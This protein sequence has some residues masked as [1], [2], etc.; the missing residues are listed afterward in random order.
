MIV[1][2]RDRWA[3][4]QTDRIEHV[5]GIIVGGGAENGSA[6]SV[7]ET[8]M[9]TGEPLGRGSYDLSYLPRVSGSHRLHFLLLEP[10]INFQMHAGLDLNGILST[11]IVSN[12][13]FDWG[14]YEMHQND[15]A[16]RSDLRNSRYFL[17]HFSGMV[18]F[19][20]AE[21]FTFLIDADPD[22]ILVLMIDGAVIHTTG[23]SSGGVTRSGSHEGSFYPSNRNLLHVF[24]LTY[25]HK[26]GARAFVRCSW[27]RNPTVPFV[28]I[29]HTAFFHGSLAG[30]K[31][32]ETDIVSGLGDGRS[33]SLIKSQ[34]SFHVASWSSIAL[35]E[36]RD[37]CANLRA[38]GGD[39]PAIFIHGPGDLRVTANMTDFGN[40]TYEATVFAKT[41]GTRAINAF[42]SAF[43]TNQAMENMIG[44]PW[45]LDFVSISFSSRAAFLGGNAMIAGV[46]AG[47]PARI[48]LKGDAL[49]N[50]DSKM[51]LVVT[52]DLLPRN[53]CAQLNKSITRGVRRQRHLIDFVLYTIGTYHVQLVFNDTMLGMS[54]KL[55]CRSGTMSPSWSGVRVM[56]SVKERLIDSPL[57]IQARDEFG[58]EIATGGE[59]IWTQLYGPVLATGVSYD[60]SDGTYAILYNFR[61]LSPGKYAMHV[62]VAQGC[63]RGQHGGGLTAHYFIDGNT[64]SVPAVVREESGPIVFDWG[65]KDLVDGAADHVS[66]RWTGLLEAPETAFFR[67]VVRLSDINDVA[68]VSIDD[69]IVTET[70]AGV[71]FGHV[72]LTRGALYGISVE[73]YE[74]TG[75]AAISVEWS[76][77]EMKAQPVGA[78]FLF[79]SWK[80]LRGSPYSFE[81]SDRGFFQAPT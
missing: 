40:G 74:S 13:V 57:L 48:I 43:A 68:R 63:S 25:V 3:N 72:Y 41:V 62:D 69:A 79:P 47:A 73:F 9:V 42:A 35:V 26:R 54:A 7:Q 80:T 70:E 15:I 27:R 16:I 10:G 52:L 61:R 38:Q 21:Q 33:S 11:D 77:L 65:Q 71:G 75:P 37:S 53:P 60:F 17:S 64:S 81:V 46:I 28:L 31:A 45:I 6:L 8:I 19:P 56:P 24:E 39:G 22:A 30:G 14:V 18:Q 34:G 36:L 12:L 66:V 32:I 2:A 58:N 49:G 55:Q 59:T 78:A 23:F 76:S 29:P 67:L 50:T 1:T 44:V 51:Q 20:V 5:L 4:V